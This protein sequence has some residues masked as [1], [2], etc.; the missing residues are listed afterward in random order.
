MLGAPTP[1]P[2]IGDNIRNALRMMMSSNTATTSEPETVSRN[3][4]INAFVILP[5]TTQTTTTVET[6]SELSATST[7]EK[8]VLSSRNRL[9]SGSF[10]ILPTIK[11][12]TIMNPTERV[13]NKTAEISTTTEDSETTPEPEEETTWEEYYTVL[14]T[15]EGELDEIDL[16]TEA[17]TRTSNE[18]TTAQP[19][20]KSSTEPKTNPLLSSTTLAT[21]TRRTSPTPATRSTYPPLIT[22]RTF[23]TR[24]TSTTTRKPSLTPKDTSNKVPGEATVFKNTGIKFIPLVPVAPSNPPRSYSSTRR[25]PIVPKA[26][27]R[28]RIQSKSTTKSPVGNKPVLVEVTEAYLP[29]VNGIGGIDDTRGVGFGGGIING[30]L[31]PSQGEYFLPSLQFCVFW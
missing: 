31:N 16:Q 14:I 10:I 15:T 30:N 28:T 29:G 9:G 26:T 5:T 22:I 2:N 7:Q 21:S 11:T 13:E 3:R 12:T 17:A 23:P 18:E 24:P 4:F 8:P 27:S 20:S 1:A 19:T 6:D 25:P